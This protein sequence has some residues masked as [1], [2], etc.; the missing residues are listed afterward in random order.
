V[1]IRVRVEEWL[2]EVLERR[3]RRGSFVVDMDIERGEERRLDRL[4]LTE[5]DI[6][7]DEPDWKPPPPAL[8]D[9]WR[10]QSTLPPYR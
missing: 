4:G 10:P 2:L 6:K 7:A 3:R 9:P 5:D 8:A 1:S